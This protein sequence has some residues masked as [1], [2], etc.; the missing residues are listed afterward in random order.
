MV[1][2]PQDR[3]G[4][5]L[6]ARLGPLAEAEP[7]GCFQCP[8]LLAMTALKTSSHPRSGRTWLHVPNTRITSWKV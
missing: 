8:V 6:L 2:Q 7:L 5:V 3:E 1:A 4:S